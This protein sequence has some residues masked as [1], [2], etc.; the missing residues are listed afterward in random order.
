[1]RIIDADKKYMYPDEELMKE[2]FTLLSGEIL[3]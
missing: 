3:P 2:W 1:M